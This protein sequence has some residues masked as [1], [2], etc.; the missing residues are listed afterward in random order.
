MDIESSQG[1]DPLRRVHILI[2][3]YNGRDLLE[4]YV[5]SVVEAAHR[6]RHAC[7]VSVID[8][9]SS[10]GSV[11]FLRSR[12]PGVG[13]FEA[14]ENRV[15]C[16]FNE[17][18]QQVDEEILIFLNNDIRLDPKFVDPLLG[19]FKDPNL[20]F[21]APK[22]CS[23]DG[24]FRG[25]VNRG[26]F[27]FG[28]FKSVVPQDHPDALQYTLSAHGGAV[29]R[30]KFLAL[31]GYD[32]LYLPGYVE[33]LDLCYR[34]WRR[35]WVGLY[36]PQSVMFHEGGAS[37]NKLFGRPR[38]L[39]LIHRNVFLFFWK[40]VSSSRQWGAHGVWLVPR[41]LV[42]LVTP[43]RWPFI[44]G[45]S[46]ALGRIGQA[47][48]RRKVVL[49]T[50]K[51][52]D[53]EVLARVASDP[54]PIPSQEDV[55]AANIEYH[56]KVA[57]RYEQDASTLGIFEEG[58][59][60][61]RRVEGVLDYLVRQTGGEKLL[62]IGCGTG[63]VLS[64]AAGR[65]KQ[66]MGV[67]ASTGMLKV[68][69]SRGLSVIL[70]DALKLPWPDGTFDAAT[71]FSVVHHF[72]KPSE[73]FREAYRVLKPGGYLYTD[74]DPNAKAVPLWDAQSQSG[75]FKAVHGVYM[76]TKKLLGRVP[77]DVRSES[78]DMQKL[79]ELA[80]YHHHKEKGLD[81]EKIS[82]VLKEAG[83]NEV[84]IFFHN[85]SA[86]LFETTPRSLWEKTK[87]AARMILNGRFRLPTLQESC[88]NFAI[89]ARK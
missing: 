40:N 13:L 65:F 23:I 12:F 33:D 64:N 80:E 86:D 7:K 34:A 45:F 83:F 53:E 78:S 68:A 22:E 49:G 56:D 32:D 47:F 41:L 81:A 55:L 77:K 25:G 58:K 14:R 35:G 28:F 48:K 82:D 44:Q 21:V 29:S 71:A 27:S 89:L 62:D 43:K 79:A 57:E 39:A 8:N 51:L 2:L 69:R 61:Q 74:W 3:N 70:A 10:D 85:N 60:S 54:V 16:S 38:T 73:L 50:F 6:S 52:S 46:M 67:D 18:V 24:K 31:G 42:S 76:G 15:L 75:M 26:C 9:A 59:G 36:E 17:V 66:A 19:H 5:P 88:P 72:L 11:S 4:K 63:N 1:P 87:L 84:R 20:F 37:F 30:E